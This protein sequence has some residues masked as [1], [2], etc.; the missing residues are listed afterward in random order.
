MRSKNT[1]HYSTIVSFVNKYYD[2]LIKDAAEDAP[3]TLTTLLASVIDCGNHILLYPLLRRAN[4]R[5]AIGS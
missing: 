5:V 4:S 2:R 3:D 1:A